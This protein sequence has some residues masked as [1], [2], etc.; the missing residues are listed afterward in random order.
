MQPLGVEGPAG[1]E[2]HQFD[3]VFRPQRGLTA[4]Q[5]GMRVEDPSAPGLRRNPGQQSLDRP[6]GHRGVGAGPQRR[7]QRHQPGQHRPEPGPLQ[8]VHGVASGDHQGVREIDLSD[9]QLGEGAL[10]V[11]PCPAE[12]V[13]CFVTGRRRQPGV[14]VDTGEH[15]GYPDVPRRGT[16][17]PADDTGHDHLADPLAHRLRFDG[18]VQGEHDPVHRIAGR[19]SAQ[20]RQQICLQGA[21][22]AAVRQFVHGDGGRAAVGHGAAHDSLPEFG[23]IVAHHDGARGRA[24]GVRDEVDGTGRITVQAGDHH[25][26][27]AAVSGI[28]DFWELCGMGHHYPFGNDFQ[29]RPGTRY[30]VDPSLSKTIVIIVHVGGSPMSAHC[31][32]TGRKPGFGK[33]VSHSHKRTSRRWDPNIQRKT[34]YLPSEGRRI[35]LDVSAK[36]IKTIDR[37]GI[38]AVVARLRARGTRI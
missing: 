27:C 21:R 30:S 6:G 8:R 14:R 2:F 24:E 18:R 4:Q 10:I 1:G 17:H 37:D 23:E 29:L 28:D 20:Q 13:Q 35:T 5:R 26:R 22:D 9:G 12:F 25:D 31:Q 7:G 15:G 36:G 38:E 16:V 33:A 3:T 34:Y 19:E 11:G 32:V